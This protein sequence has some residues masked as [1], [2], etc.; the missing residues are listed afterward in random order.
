VKRNGDNLPAMVW[1]VIGVVFGDIGTSPLYAFRVCFH[2]SNAVSP[3]APNVLGVLSLIFWALVLV[4]SIKY[5]G[6]ILRAD[7]QGEGGILALMALVMQK[8]AKRAGFVGLAG[9][10]GAA[11]LYGDGTITPA[12]SVLSAV[13]GLKTQTP[14]LSP[15]VMPISLIVLLLLFLYQRSGTARVG[16]LWGGVMLIWFPVLAVLGAAHVARAPLVLEAI[17]PA[18]AVRFLLHHGLQSFFILGGV[19]LTVTGGEALYAD[20]GHF[21][22]R[23]IRVAWFSIVLPSLLLNY[24][25]QG[26][27]LLTDSSA[28]ANPFYHMAP[29]W[30]LFPLVTLST[31]A[32]IIASQAIVSGVYSLTFQAQQLGFLPRLRTLHTSEEKRGQI[33]MPQVNWLLFAATVGVVIGFRSSEGLSAAYGVAVS[34]T[35]L[36]TTLLGSLV[37][38]RLW[39]WSLSLVIPVASLFL[40][41]DALFLAANLLKIF[42]GGWYPLAVGGAVYAAMTTWAMGQDFIGRQVEARVAPPAEFLAGLEK[43]NLPRV[44]GTAVYLSRGFRSVPLAFIHNVNHN[45]V[46]H[47]RVIFLTVE[48]LK[49]PYVRSENR[50]EFSDLAAG[51]YRLIIRYGFMDNPNLS[52]ALRIVQNKYLEIDLD[53]TT[54]FLGRETLIPSRSFGLSYWRDV[55]FLM[56]A[57]NSERATDYFNL[58]ADRVFEVGARI[59]F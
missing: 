2:G 55:V 15:L 35:M 41:I 16:L 5:L 37:F 13:E 11:L 31:L 39:K 27:L 20:L 23:P 8:G 53:D 6:L 51:Y 25:G 58:P 49:E 7:N 1:S 3:D 48:F 46:I 33:Y 14:L 18:H 59:R 4:I 34:A 29:R 26:A 12:I 54:F 56:M 21:G 10:F 45:K 22:R 44:S 57:R 17:Y 40:S 30:A 24:F 32:T 47:A 52:A 43:R 9:L 28:A 19:F 38:H 50:I 42:A 36:I